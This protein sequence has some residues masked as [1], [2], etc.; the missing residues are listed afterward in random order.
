MKMRKILLS[1]LAILFIGSI[2]LLINK[3]QFQDSNKDIVDL[4]EQHEAFLKNSPFK[5]SLKLSKKERK[6]QGLPPNKYSERMWELTMNPEKGYPEPG[7]LFKLQDELTERAKFAKVPGEDTN[8]WV[9]RGPDNVGGRTRAIMFDP[10]DNTNKR[11]FAGG[12]S[13]GLW[14]NNDITDANSAWAE[15]GIPD[16]LAISCITYDPNNTNTFYVGTG[17]SYVAGDVNG[18]GVWKSTDGGSN[19]V[20]VFGGVTGET[21]VIPGTS[22]PG[23]ARIIVNTPASIAGEYSAQQAG[24]GPALEDLTGDLVLADDGTAA[25]NEACNALTNGAAM[26]GNI[27]ILYRG[28]CGFSLK[29]LNAQNA[30]AVAVIVVNNVADTALV[31]MAGGDDGDSVTIPSIF[32]TQADGQT[33]I[34]ALASGVNVSIGTLPPSYAGFSNSP[35]VQ[36]INDIVVRDIGSGNSEVFVA[37]GSSFFGDASPSVLLGAEDYGLYKS[38]DDGSNWS[39]INLVSPAEYKY[40]PNDLEIGVDNTIWLA[41]TNTIV[42]GGGGEILS[43]TDGINFNLQYTVPNGSRTQ[44]AVSNSDASTLY[45]LAATG[46]TLAL[47]KTTDAFATTPVDLSQPDDADT[48]IAADDFTRGQAFYDLMLEV[49]PVDDK[50]VYVGGIDLF[51]SSDSGT[52]WDQLSHW[53]G[54]FGYQEVHADQ[55]AMTFD[56]SDSNKA[57]FGHDGGVSYA[58]SLTDAAATGTS[59]IEPRVNNYNTLQFYNG[60]IGQEVANEKLLAGAQDNGSQL[61]NNASAGI[62]GSTEVSGG[63]G[64][65][66]FIDKDNEYMISS[67]YYN[68]YLYKDY[69]TGNGVYVIDSDE[70]SGDF[71]NSAAL[72]SDTNYLYTN[73][74]AGTDYKVNVYALGAGSATKTTITDATLDGTPTAFKPLASTTFLRKLLVGTENGK[75]FI[76]SVNNFGDTWT[77]ITGPGFAGSI[78]CIETGATEDDIY[79]TFYN[80]GVSNVFYSSNGGSTWQNKEGD[81]PDLPVRAILSNPLNRNEVILATDLGVWGT[82]DF[83]AS[84]P[85]WARA[86]NGMKDVK[87]TSFDLR[88]ADNTVLAS[89]Y[90]RGMF[91]GQFTSDASTLSLDNVDFNDAIKVYPTISDGNFKIAASNEVSNG[92]LNI[93][94]L[95]GR[96]VYTSKIDFNSNRIQN[97]SLNQSSGMYIVKFKSDTRQSSYKI[98]IK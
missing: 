20:R 40:S 78:S 62:N 73:G 71:I 75:L 86:Q 19:W 56:P 16:N 59:G 48:G 23:N 74:S 10:N 82:A 9:E 67:I 92:I 6:A 43:S 90:G 26:A 7:K 65:Y 4:R 61:I 45:V 51:R 83:S 63:D 70:D 12:V 24:Y 8:S 37:A 3:Y 81:L 79:V 17:E 89:T 68:R 35:G 39:E 66:V 85:D 58:T 96:E 33:L 95:N 13:G 97:I 94:D 32:V 60:A 38:S 88:T 76:V 36:H 72:D 77:Q 1:L 31:T 41:T 27:A 49:N 28:S 5:E 47:V 25:P 91:T 46:S 11:V 93:Y 50:I 42:F 18:N 98:V 54:G 57:L 44:I 64:A 15:V 55:H 34:N 87:V 14:V 2:G 80:Y 22:V 69:T 29:V 84:T 30:G 53:Y 21:A 52:N